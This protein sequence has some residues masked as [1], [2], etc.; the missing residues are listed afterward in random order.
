[1]FKFSYTSGSA[2]LLKSV[3]CDNSAES[4]D[5]PIKESERYPHQGKRH[6]DQGE[7]QTSQKGG[8]GCR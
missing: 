6:P 7:R 2:N 3:D 1:M 4:K 5:E 8:C